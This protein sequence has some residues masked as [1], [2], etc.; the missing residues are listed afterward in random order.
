MPTEPRI[1]T[2][3]KTPTIAPVYAE[4]AAGEGGRGQRGGW[5]PQVHRRACVSSSQLT[6]HRQADLQLTDT[7]QVLAAAEVD[8]FVFFADVDDGQLEVGVGP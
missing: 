1:S 3:R 8:A 5:E 4:D 2:A 7:K 6:F